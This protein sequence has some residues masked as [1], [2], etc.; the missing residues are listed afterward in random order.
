ML[1]EE[2]QSDVADSSSEIRTEQWSLDLE[3]WVP[4]TQVDKMALAINN[5]FTHCRRR[6]GKVYSIVARWCVNVVVEVVGVAL[7]I[8]SIFPLKQKLRLLFQKWRYCWFE[9]RKGSMKY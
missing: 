9:E 4:V 1:N 6:E 5:D 3:G 8:T 2:R 7:V